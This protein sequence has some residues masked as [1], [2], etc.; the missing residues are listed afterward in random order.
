MAAADYQI[1]HVRYGEGLVLLGPK[2]SMSL[3]S[4]SQFVATA[5]PKVWSAIFGH[6]RGIWWW[7]HIFVRHRTL[8]SKTAGEVCGRVKRAEENDSNGACAI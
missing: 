7:M 6:L 8:N 2:R 1:H 5:V 3:I 4:R